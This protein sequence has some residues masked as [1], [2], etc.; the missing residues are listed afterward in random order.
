MIPSINHESI[1]PVKIASTMTINH[2]TKH[3]AAKQFENMGRGKQILRF[4][5]AED[6][7]SGGGEGMNESTFRE[8]E[9]DR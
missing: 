3:L 1:N 9:A 7:V 5:E 8:G 6:Q 4:Q 2:S